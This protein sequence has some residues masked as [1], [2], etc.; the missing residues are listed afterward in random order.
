MKS[1]SIVVAID[2]K[3]GIGKEGSLAWKLSADLKHFKELTSKASEGKQNAVIMGRKTWDFLPAKFKPLPGRL[4]VVLS[5][6]PSVQLS[7]GVLLFSNLDNA[8][9]GVSSNS[10]VDK[11]FVIGG[12]QIYTQALG[13]PS[14]Q[15]LFVTH[16]KGDFHCD[17]FLHLLP[18]VFKKIEE[19]SWVS[20][21]S[22]QYRFCQYQK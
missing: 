15:K 11:V 12:A 20:E 1:F 13:H 18:T 5:H 3:N 8:L 4:N 19:S 16:I 2:E 9:K 22:I 17:T 21:G 14:C 10:T 6:N 7:A